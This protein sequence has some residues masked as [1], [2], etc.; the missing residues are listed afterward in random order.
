MLKWLGIVLASLTLLWIVLQR[1]TLAISSLF[2]GFALAAA[3]FAVICPTQEVVLSSKT[4]E[5]SQKIEEVERRAA[6]TLNGIKLEMQKVEQKAIRSEERC[7][8]YQKLADVH[9][10]E[11]EKLRLENQALADQL[12]Q[13]ER[14]LGALHFTRSEPDLFDWIEMQQ[15]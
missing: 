3:L 10:S 8:S 1:E 12:V 14:K 6:E 9:Q 13:K 11:I 15:E 7:L 5:I 2:A 4:E